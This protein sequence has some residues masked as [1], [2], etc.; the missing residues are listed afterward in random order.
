[1]VSLSS[2]VQAAVSVPA[3]SSAS[4]AAQVWSFSYFC[5]MIARYSVL[6]SADNA[7]DANEAV[8]TVKVKTPSRA[9]MDSIAPKK[10]TRVLS[11]L[12][13]R[14]CAGASDRSKP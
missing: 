1:M 7:A 2:W 3:T 11:P 9:R 6:Q 10:Q 4:R 14:V 8:A 5:A 12:P 13:L